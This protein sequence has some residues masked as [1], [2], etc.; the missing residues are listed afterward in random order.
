MTETD[1]ALTQQQY[2][3]MCRRGML[4]LD[5]ILMK[6]VNE[7]F[8]QWDKQQKQDIYDF[9]QYDDPV[10]FDLLITKKIACEQRFQWIVNNIDSR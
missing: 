3:W 2:Q 5:L 6:L 9:L 10:L 8:S 1:K 7:H 4:E